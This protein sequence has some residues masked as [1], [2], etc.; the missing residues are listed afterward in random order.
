[1]GN[2]KQARWQGLIAA[3]LNVTA[4]IFALVFAAVAMGAVLG[5]YGPTYY[6]DQCRDRNTVSSSSFS[7]FCSLAHHYRGYPT[8]CTI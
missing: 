4:V 3:Y 5:I 1:M 6:L 8:G 2:I 7:K